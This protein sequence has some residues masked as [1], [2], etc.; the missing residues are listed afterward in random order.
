MILDQD[1]IKILLPHRHPFLFLDKCQI[2]E[3]GV[4]GI[5]F[6]KFLKED[7]KNKVCKK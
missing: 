7:I 6:R 2:L 1:E 4:K 3:L 5:G